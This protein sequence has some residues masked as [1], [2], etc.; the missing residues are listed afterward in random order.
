MPITFEET[1]Q[2]VIN[3]IR[4]REQAQTIVAQQAKRIEELEAQLGKLNG[5]K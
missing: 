2:T 1:V 4:E 3:L 5:S